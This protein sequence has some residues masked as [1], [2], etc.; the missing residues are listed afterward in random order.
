MTAASG[1]PGCRSREAESPAHSLREAVSL[2][3]FHIPSAIPVHSW[4]G[5]SAFQSVLSLASVLLSRSWEVSSELRDMAAAAKTSATGQC[6]VG[7]MCKHVLKRVS[8]PQHSSLAS[9]QI[10]HEKKD[11]ILCISSMKKWKHWARASATCSKPYGRLCKSAQLS[12]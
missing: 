5:T 1:M 8:V 9:E 11:A 12:M 2:G 10:G 3:G 7:Y 6:L 4:A